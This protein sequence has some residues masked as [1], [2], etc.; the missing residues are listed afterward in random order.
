MNRRTQLKLENAKIFMKKNV[1]SGRYKVRNTLAVIGAAAIIGTV[2]LTVQGVENKAQENKTVTAMVAESVEN[3]TAVEPAKEYVIN[4]SDSACLD[5]TSISTLYSRFEDDDEVL[6]AANDSESLT[7]SEND[8]TGKFIVTTEGLNMRKET[9]EDANILT[10]LNTG[11]YGDVIES[12]GEWTLVAFVDKQG[13]LKTDYIVMDEDATKIAEQAAKEGKSYREVIG[14]EEIVPV[15]TEQTTEATTQAPQQEAQQPSQ[16]QEAQKPVAQEPTTAAPVTEAPTEATTQEPTTA[17]P[18][19]EA[20]TEA[21]TEAPAQTSSSDLYLLAAIVYAEAG[22]E[23]YE[24][25]LAVACV[26]LNRLYNGYW[27]NS[28]SSVIYAPSQF[29]GAYTS[30]FSNALS[31]GGSATSLQAAQDAL[32]GA[33]NVGGCM[34]FRPTWNIDTSSLGNYIQIGNHIF[35]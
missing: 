12:D 30:A 32:N 26:V 14:V 11:D 27:G 1:F 3:D 22:G 35:Y 29:T 18:V 4:I 20:P 13:Y 8:M 7:A 10:V 9:S 24:G 15:S 34:Y 5:D 21:A 17:A 31:T 25:Q 33:N 6:T 16:Q 23:S 2:G 19:T 28:L